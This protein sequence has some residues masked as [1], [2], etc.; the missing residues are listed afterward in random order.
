MLLFIIIC[1]SSCTTYRYIY[2][3]SA[4]NEPYFT[5]KGESKLTGYYSSGKSG[6][7]TNK[8]A[9]GYDLQAAYAFADH[10]AATASYFSRNEKD[11]YPDDRYNLFDSSIIKYKRNLPGIGAGYFVSLNDKRTVTFNLYG[12]IA[13]GKFSFRD[14]G[15]NGGTNYSRF[16]NS[17][18]TKWYFQPAFNFMPSQLF[19][20]S[21]VVT[22]SYVNYSHIKTSYTKNEL[23]YF[24]L[25]KIA[26]KT[27]P[28]LEPSLNLQVGLRQYPWIKLDAT[29]SGASQNFPGDYRLAVRSSNASIGLTFDFSKI[30]KSN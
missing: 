18:I 3:A 6:D 8:Y 21:I 19:R 2:S 29:V 30:K 14:D 4:P 11:V 28:F 9:R 23:Q 22:A 26:N 27:L 17:Q 24:S 20:F 10:W 16:Y 25:D 15:L 1:L 5:K 13:K 12:G 7:F